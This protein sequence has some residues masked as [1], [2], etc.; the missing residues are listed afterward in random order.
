MRLNQNQFFCLVILGFLSAGCGASNVE[1]SAAAK[2]AVP[3]RVIK[4]ERK[5]LQNILDYVG[6]VKAQEEA[7][8][9]PKVSGKIIEKL[10]EE[11]SRVSKGETLVYIDR[12]EVGFQFEKAPVESPLTGIVGRVN[13]DIGTSVTPQ[14]AVALVVDMDRAKIELDIPEK[15]LPMI[16]LGQEAR[17]TVEAYPDEKF[18]GKVSKI[19]PVLDLET[20]TAPIEIV[21]DNPDH[22]LKSGMFAQVELVIE[23][24]K[25]AAVILKEAILGKEPDLYVY[26]V[27]GEVARRRNIKTGIH[28]GQE[29][30]IT[31]GLKEGEMVVIMGQQRLYD[32]TSVI[33]ETAQQDQR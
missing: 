22:R 16:S 6:N 20:R 18:T 10:K 13:V 21:I 23:E 7:F 3:V 25:D 30:E 28:Y 9:Y 14:T 31:E 12:D 11:G 17:I 19:S 5:A 33:I 8:V 15:Y 29:Y 2:E 32:G 27:E 1:K 4:V 26:V 24:H